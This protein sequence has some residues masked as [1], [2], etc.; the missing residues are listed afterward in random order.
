MDWFLSAIAVGICFGFIAFMHLYFQ[1]RIKIQKMRDSGTKAKKILMK[2]KQNLA[3]GRVYE[4]TDNVN[5]LDRTIRSMLF[6]VRS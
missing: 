4:I 3:D 2:I 1:E 6:E 5:L